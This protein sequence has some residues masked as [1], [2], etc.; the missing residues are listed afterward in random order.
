M[1]TKFVNNIAAGFFFVVA[2]IMK[3]KTIQKCKL[4]RY[5]INSEQVLVTCIFSTN[6]QF[7]PSLRACVLSELLATIATIYEYTS[8]RTLTLY[9]SAEVSTWAFLC[10]KPVTNNFTRP[11]EWTNARQPDNPATDC[12][13]T[14]MKPCYF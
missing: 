10:P 4:V 3:W 2:C 1:S 8:F 11:T 7:H 9:E 5:I 14:D 6:F 12:H 13:A